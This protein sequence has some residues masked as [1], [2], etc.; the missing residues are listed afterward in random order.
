MDERKTDANLN[1]ACEGLRVLEDA[2]RFDLN[3]AVC[4]CSI[5]AIRFPTSAFLSVKQRVTT[6]VRIGLR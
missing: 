2:A 4:G 6:A 3:R 5:T 1:R